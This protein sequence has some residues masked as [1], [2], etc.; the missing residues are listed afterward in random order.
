MPRANDGVERAFNG[1]LCG[2]ARA[3]I[4]IGRRGCARSGSGGVNFKGR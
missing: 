2:A 1:Y 4:D 3:G